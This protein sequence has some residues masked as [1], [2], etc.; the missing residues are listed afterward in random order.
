[1]GVYPSRGGSGRLEKWWSKDWL[2]E[3]RSWSWVIRA[4]WGAARREA[5]VGVVGVGREGCVRVCV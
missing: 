5:G 4:S 2:G 3:R 1:M